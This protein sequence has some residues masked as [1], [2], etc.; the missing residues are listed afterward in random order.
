M[1]STTPTVSLEKDLSTPTTIHLLVNNQPHQTSST[2]PV[3]NPA[4]GDF[5]HHFGSAAID[6][7]DAALAAAHKAFPAWRDTKPIKRRNILLKAAELMEVRREELAG[8][9]M[10]ET[11]ASTAW[12][13]FNLGLASE[14]L[15]D[16]AARISSIQ[17]SIP[18]PEGEG[19]SGMICK[20]PYGVILAIAPWNAPFILG[21][22]SIVYPLAAGNT[23]LLKASELAPACS[24]AL[25][26]IFHDAGLPDGVLNLLA[27]K[28]ADA[29]EVTKHL[30][31]SPI[32]K[33]IN[34]TG[35]TNVGRII[36]ELAG[37][38]L[39]PVLLELGGKNPAIIWEDADLELAAKEC[40]VGAFLNSGQ[41]CMSTDRL[42]VHE[43]VV[44][45]FEKLFKAAVAAFAPED[46][47][48]GVLINKQSVEKTKR[49][50]RDAVSKGA[51]IIYGDIE[52]GVDAKMRPVVVKGTTREMDLYHQETFGPTVSIIVIKSEEEAVELA[53][54]TEYGLTS[55]VFTE[56]LRRALRF[57]KNIESGAVHINGM[58]VHDETALPHGGKSH[59]FLKPLYQRDMLIYDVKA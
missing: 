51:T 40:A 9:M 32:I 20:E 52:S 10:S 42:L 25:V 14:I 30:I 41:I 12:A 48:P 21:M 7:A 27:H 18:T 35:S 44:D 24:H 45:E 34:F 8:Y 1:S 4:T 55:S 50:L 17:G 29:A 2:F 36:G 26:R 19:I 56:D 23:A 31:D 47:E 57:A 49:I 3:H 39:K 54:D 15:R 58:T 37:R 38:N 28:P 5:V 22:R 46:K 59:T 11:G 43:K 16:A 6:D 33:K 53:N 13:N